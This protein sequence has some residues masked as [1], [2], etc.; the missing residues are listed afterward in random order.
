MPQLP[1]DFQF[2][3]A[4]SSY[5]IEGGVTEG[6]RGRSVW[7]DFCDRSGVIA[8]GS[9]GDVACDSYH[10]FG[11]DIELMSGLGV[12]AYRFSIAWPRVL[13]DGTGSVNQAGLDYYDRL[14]DAL[15]AKGIQPAAT[16]FHWDLPSAL[17]VDGGWLQRDTAE[18]FADYARIVIARLGDRV[19]QWMTLNEPNVFTSLGYSTGIHAPGRTLGLYALPVAHH[20][21]LGHGLAVSALRAGGACSVGLAGNH[22]VVWPR[23]DSEADRGAAELFDTMWN[24]IYTDPILLGRYPEGIAAVMPGPVDIDLSVI[25]A[26]IDFYG[27][28]YYNPTCVGIPGNGSN[29]GANVASDLPFDHYPITGYPVTDFGWPVVP[30]GLTDVLTML[31]ERYGDRLPP[32]Y[33]TENGACYNDGP[34]ANGVVADTGRID[35]YNS[36]IRAVAD[37]IDLGVDVRGYFAWSLLDNFEWAEGYSKRFGLVHVDFDTLV[38]TP[39]QSYA[40]YADL[41][42]RTKQA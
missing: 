28:N 40:W 37:A 25:S 31:K 19:S 32:V 2:G 35:Y 9:N 41:I 4:T 24:R 6:G 1:P 17:E 5:Q 23:S 7:D 11:E 26:P 38:R 15:C 12:D 33:I 42:A 36:H 29:I 8:D 22:T 18:A 39:K 14:V 16:L 13:P 27:V 20:L 10:R 21:M 30:Q 3:V 34:D